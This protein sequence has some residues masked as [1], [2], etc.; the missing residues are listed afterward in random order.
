[1]VPSDQNMLRALE[2][3]EDNI[4]GDLSLYDISAAA[5]FSV[6][7]FCRLFRRLT[8]ACIAYEYGFESHDVFTR[9][10]ARVYG[11]TPKKFRDSGGAPPLKRQTVIAKNPITNNQQMNFS[12]FIRKRLR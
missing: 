5:G 11:M 2:F 7:H 9:A 4:T 1:M 8:I 10:F 12:L 3:I 6:P